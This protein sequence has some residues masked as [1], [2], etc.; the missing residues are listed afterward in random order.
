MRRR[1]PTA[2]SIIPVIL[3]KDLRA[4]TRN[5]LYL[6]LSAATLVGFV[7]VFWL[8]PDTVDE[9]ITLAMAPPLAELVPEDPTVLLEAGFSP[10]DLAELETA[11]VEEDEGLELVELAS[12]AELRS[13]V[14]GDLEAYRTRDGDLFL[15]DP[16]SDASPPAG[17]QRLRP[18]VGIA[19]PAGFLEDLVQG[20]ETSV[21]LVSRAGVPPEIRGAM[22]S[23]VRE[24]AFQFAGQEFP[25]QMPEEEAVVL[26]PDRLG[27]PISLQERV[28]PLL[29]FFVL[30]METF[31]M[32]SLVSTEV[33]QRTVTALLVTPMRIWHFLAAKTI[34]GTG[35]ALSQ[36]VILLA[37]V[38][39]F[40]PENWALL[41]LTMLVGS[42]MFTALAMMIGSLGR[43]FLSELMYAMLFTIPLIIPAF[44]VLFP[45]TAAP[46]VR[47]LPS[48]PIVEL[49]E[50]ITIYGQ[51]WSESLGALG[52]GA[53]WGAALYLL[54]LMVLKRKVESL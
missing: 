23:M 15:Y 45:G 19:F 27:D 2:G 22:E 6:V 3:R 9:E 31:A 8:L 13:V 21:T 28:R 40:T 44:A 33:L 7:A 43:D 12:E 54:G 25:A 5:R 17:A 14:A 48:Y 29:A 20:K 26:G 49:L 24:I 34:F 30:L 51:G 41:L 47:V 39:A 35:L 4:Y 53:A 11:E 32:S 50:G 46:W 18:E 36:G 42:V 16:G 52:Y 38:G 10:R 1:R 37:L